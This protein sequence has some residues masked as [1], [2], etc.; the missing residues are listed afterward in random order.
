M[1]T[2][3]S[4][5]GHEAARRRAIFGRRARRDVRGRPGP[6]YRDPFFT[7]AAAVEDDAR[8]FRRRDG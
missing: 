4:C 6:G 5:T 3:E 2:D 1:N 7:D 8:R